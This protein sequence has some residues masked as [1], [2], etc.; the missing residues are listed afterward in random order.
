MNRGALDENGGNRSKR[1]SGSR[2]TV[3]NTIASGCRAAAASIPKSVFSVAFIREIGTPSEIP[4]ASTRRRALLDEIPVDR[5]SHCDAVGF[6]TIPR[7][8][9]RH[10]G[11]AAYSTRRVRSKPMMV[12]PPVRT[13]TRESTSG[14]SQGPGM[15]RQSNSAVPSRNGGIKNDPTVTPWQMIKR[16]FTANPLA[17]T[18]RSSCG[19]SPTS[20]ELGE[21]GFREAVSIP[22]TRV[23]TVTARGPPSGRRLLAKSPSPQSCGGGQPLRDKSRWDRGR[24]LSDHEARSRQTARTACRP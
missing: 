4:S 3:A 21:A 12:F 10:V 14:E 15:C 2:P 8:P 5:A 11:G 19:P 1:P 23:H 6:L 16:S 24:R 17:A 20:A 7:S 9:V 18:F 13:R 22:H